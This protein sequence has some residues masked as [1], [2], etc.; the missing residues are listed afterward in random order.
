MSSALYRKE[1]K[2]SAKLLVIFAAVLSL[3]ICMIISMY[4]PKMAQ[5]LEQFE[6]MM[7]N[8]RISGARDTCFLCLQRKTACLRE[9]ATQRLQLIFADWQDLKNADSAV[10]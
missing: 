5:A 1:M 10:K 3:Y 9:T 2:G 4:D 8:L 7:P 6:Q